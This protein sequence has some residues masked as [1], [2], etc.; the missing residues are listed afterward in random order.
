MSKRIGLHPASETALAYRR[1]VGSGGAAT[2]DR[3]TPTKEGTAGAVAIMADGNGTTSER[4]SGLAKSVSTDTA[5]VAGVVEVYFPFPG[6][7]Y[8]AKPKV[9]GAANTQAEIDALAGKRTVFDL[10]TGDWTIDAAA[11][12]G[13]T[14]GL[15]IVGGNLQDD[16][17][18]F[19]VSPTVSIYE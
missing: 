16:V 10:T 4:F 6:I 7:V 1:I 12:D 5:S 11:V 13:A 18:Y 14:N 19:V 15:V 8:F 2:I 3:G 17:L 9:A